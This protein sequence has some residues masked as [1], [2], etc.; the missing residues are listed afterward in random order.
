LGTAFYYQ[1]QEHHFQV[2]NC[3]KMPTGLFQKK[4]STVEELVEPW[5]LLLNQL[6]AKLVILTV[7]PIRHLKEGLTENQHSKSVLRVACTELSKQLAHVH[8]FPAYEIMLDD[9]RDYRF[10]EADMIHPNQTAQ[11]YI[12]DQF[13]ETF[14]QPATRDIMGQWHKVQ[15]N[16]QH[17]PF[18][19]GTQQ[20]HQ[21]VRNTLE[22]IDRLPNHIDTAQEIAWLKKQLQ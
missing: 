13:I 14:T 8:Y 17:K 7:S 12:W 19:T 2:A 9:L 22:M 1:H 4:C 15:K 6:P 11:D 18:Q 3:H 10:Y 16:L 20:H 5:L 21:F